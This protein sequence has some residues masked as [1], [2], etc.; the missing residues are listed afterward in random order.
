MFSIEHISINIMTLKKIESSEDPTSKDV[1]VIATNWPE[2]TE[3][4]ERIRND[5]PGMT[6][7]Y[8]E[9]KKKEGKGPFSEYG[10]YYEE[11]PKGLSYKT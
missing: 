2:P 7:I 8:H 1:L 3:T 11:V 6:V 10:M 4:L 5:H 9:L